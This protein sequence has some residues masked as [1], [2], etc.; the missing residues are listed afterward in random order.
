MGNIAK[1]IVDNREQRRAAFD[2]LSVAKRNGRK[3]PGSMKK[4]CKQQ[5]GSPK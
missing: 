3:R 1:K 4:K 5:P 2:A